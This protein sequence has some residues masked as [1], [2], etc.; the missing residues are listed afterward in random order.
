MKLLVMQ[1]SPV[2]RHLGR[3]GS[4]YKIKLI[5]FQ[6]VSIQLCCTQSGLAGQYRHGL[7]RHGLYR[8]EHMNV[9]CRRSLFHTTERMKTFG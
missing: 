9:S 3:L 7:Y 4:K 2:A 5:I 8:A 1:F 6:G